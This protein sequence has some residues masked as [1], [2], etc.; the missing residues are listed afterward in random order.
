M[1]LSIIIIIFG[2]NLGHIT[3][4][5]FYIIYNIIVILICST[6]TTTISKY[7]VKLSIKTTELV[8]YMY[9]IFH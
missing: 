8:N 4:F 6:T 5:K 7:K 1:L 9:S 2:S 3:L